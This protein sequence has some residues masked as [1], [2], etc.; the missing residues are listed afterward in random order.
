[1]I[2]WYFICFST[3]YLFFLMWLLRSWSLNCMTRATGQLWIC[4]VDVYILYAKEKAVT[5]YFRKLSCIFVSLQHKARPRDEILVCTGQKTGNVHSQ[6]Q[7]ENRTHSERALRQWVSSGS[8]AALLW[9]PRHEQKRGKEERPRFLFLLNSCM[10]ACPQQ[11]TQSVLREMSKIHWELHQVLYAEH[12]NV[13]LE[14]S[15]SLRS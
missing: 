3:T 7:P 1:M 9:R 14:I 4:N 6:S 2:L 8:K 12:S 15:E 11:H 13:G 5:K 10:N